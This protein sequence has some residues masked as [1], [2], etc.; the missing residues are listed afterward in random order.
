MP[1]SSLLDRW[2]Y[3]INLTP[4]GNAVFI[5]MDVSDV[6]LAVLHKECRLVKTLNLTIATYFQFSKILNYIKYEKTTVV[7]FGSFVGI[8]G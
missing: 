5:T 1:H 6:F 3:L 8:W 7:V 2:S 4:I